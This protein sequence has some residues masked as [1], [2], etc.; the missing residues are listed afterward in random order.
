MCTKI[1]H[2]LLFTEAEGSVYGNLHVSL[3]LCT[4]VCVFYYLI[5]FNGTIVIFFSSHLIITLP[6]T[7]DGSLNGVRLYYYQY[8]K[9]FDHFDVF[10]ALV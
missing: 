8:Y 5:I 1:G 9:Q 10:S 7:L 4:C 3:I 2:V 6:V